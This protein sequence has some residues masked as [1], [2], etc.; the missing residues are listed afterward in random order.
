MTLVAQRTGER[1][2]NRQNPGQPSLTFVRSGG[3][4][5]CHVRKLDEDGSSE[6]SLI[7]FIYLDGQQEEGWAWIETS[8]RLENAQT[9][10]RAAVGAV[11][12]AF[13]SPD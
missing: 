2:Q 8:C 4:R 11:E 5:C 13:Q 6:V 9:A 7:R 10:S 3:S 1:R 12:E